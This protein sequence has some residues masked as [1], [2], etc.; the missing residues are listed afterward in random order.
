MKWALTEKTWSSPHLHICMKGFTIKLMMVLVWWLNTWWPL[1]DRATPTETDPSQQNKI[2]I[3]FQMNL[4]SMPLHFIYVHTYLNKRCGF[5]IYLI[6]P[7]LPIKRYLQIG[8]SIYL[9]LPQT[10]D[11]LSALSLVEI[12]G[13]KCAHRAN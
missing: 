10:A 8:K 11:Y 5:F 4:T 7:L 1:S 2:V 13:C 12:A 6:I 9:G 3:K